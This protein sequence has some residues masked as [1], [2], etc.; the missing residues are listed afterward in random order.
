MGFAAND[1]NLY[2]FVGNNP[3]NATDPS[4]LR[5]PAD[6]PLGTFPGERER[7]SP[8]DTDHRMKIHG[9]DIGGLPLKG[10]PKFTWK[11]QLSKLLR[12]ITILTGI[13]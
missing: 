12:Q 8:P 13:A 5:P 4:G 6:P 1:V 7:P 3:S 10:D 9:K 11:R 2:R